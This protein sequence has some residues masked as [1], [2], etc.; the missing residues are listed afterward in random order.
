MSIAEFGSEERRNAETLIDQGGRSVE[1]Q[2][3][4]TT[5]I[6]LRQAAE[7]GSVSRKAQGIIDHPCRRAYSDAEQLAE[8]F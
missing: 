1:F 8:E 7:M 2:A 3:G 6:G 5:A 4:S